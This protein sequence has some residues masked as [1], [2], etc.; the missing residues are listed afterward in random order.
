MHFTP[1]A[2]DPGLNRH[3]H[4]VIF[5]HNFRQITNVTEQNIEI[6]RLTSGVLAPCI[7]K[8][9]YKRS[10]LRSRLVKKTANVFFHRFRNRNVL[11]AD[12]RVRRTLSVLLAPA[13]KPA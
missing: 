7:T 13:G 2:R 5:R 3:D 8:A 10:A 1:G 12:S 4:I 11:A 9:D 6:F